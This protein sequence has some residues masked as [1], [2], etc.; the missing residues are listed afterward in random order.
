MTRRSFLGRMAAIAA[1]A[2]LAGS[3]V[4]VKAAEAAPIAD[5]MM[6][7]I[8]RDGL[9]MPVPVQDDTAYIQGMIDQVSAQ[10]GGTV[11]F[12]KRTLYI[13]RTINVPSGVTINGNGSTVEGNFS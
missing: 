8:T 11:R 1:V 2:P 3:V 6:L 5:D 4:P 9:R 7:T 12:P 13:S 10:G